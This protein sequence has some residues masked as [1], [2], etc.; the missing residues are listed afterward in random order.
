MRGDGP[1]L[2][3][4]EKGTMLMK[5]FLLCGLLLVASLEGSAAPETSQALPELFRSVAKERIFQAAPQAKSTN[6]PD[7]DAAFGSAGVE[8]WAA[9]FRMTV[10]DFTLKKTI[11]GITLTPEMTVPGKYHFYRVGTVK[12]SPDCSA[13]GNRWQA[14]FSLKNAFLREHPDLEY[15]VWFSAKF[16]E[17]ETS[18]N[19][20]IDRVVLVRAAPLPEPFSAL[21][22]EQVMQFKP[23]PRKENA[24]AP[25]AAFGFAAVEKNA[26]PFRMSVYDFTSKKTIASTMLDAGSIVP[27]RYHFYKVAT[28][29][30]TPDCGVYSNTWKGAFPLKQAY[31]SENPDQQ[32]EIYVS[33]KFPG[34]GE[35][36]NVLI[37]RAVLVK[38]EK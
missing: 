9:S 16:P 28:L 25:D 3:K 2:P 32:Y 36:G 1:P 29:K 34:R 18:G 19:V 13:C 22:P 33:A 12:L 6:I 4:N 15:D 26:S 11:A 8:K 7:A 38:V 37:D 14:E 20:L 27:G 30:L 21:T 24:V 10:Y 5:D 35:S 31:S 23:F 17:K